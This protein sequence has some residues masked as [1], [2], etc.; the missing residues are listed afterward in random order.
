MESEPE[1]ELETEKTFTIGQIMYIQAMMLS[2]K[3]VD[4]FQTI[5]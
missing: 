2:L 5:F 4:T 3:Q 1:S